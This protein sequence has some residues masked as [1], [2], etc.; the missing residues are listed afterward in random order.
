MQEITP[1]P[2]SARYYE[3]VVLNHLH[4]SQRRERDAGCSPWANPIIRKVRVLPC[5]LRAQRSIW[6]LIETGLQEK[7]PRHT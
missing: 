4:P 3:L 6:T 7:G 5:L 1:F 2:Q